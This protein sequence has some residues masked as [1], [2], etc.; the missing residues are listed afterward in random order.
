[1]E[2]T[3]LDHCLLIVAAMLVNICSLLKKIYYIHASL[4]SF[5]KIYSLKVYFSD[6]QSKVRSSYGPLV[7]FSH[8][9][10]SDKNVLHLTDANYRI[11]SVLFL[12]RVTNLAQILVDLILN[13]D[14]DGLTLNVWHSL[15]RSPKN[16]LKYIP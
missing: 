16:P 4:F 1:M 8:I 3:V 14:F 9:F 2:L 13:H 6:N 12:D 7:Y 11:D 15:I 10:I 5:N